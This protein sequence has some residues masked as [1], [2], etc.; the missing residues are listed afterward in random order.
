VLAPPPDPLLTVLTWNLDAGRGDLRAALADIAPRGDYLLLLQEAREEAV[1]AFAR[2]H[3][4]H[5]AFA[6]VRA[7]GAGNAVLSTLPLTEVR[8]ID[9]PRQR[10]PR[11]AVAAAIAVRGQ[12]LFVVSVHFEN[13]VSWW[14]GGLI[15]D[16]ARRRQAEALL[17]A[18]PA[19]APGIV[20]G[21][22]N[23]WLGP[24]EPAWRLLA[25]RFPDTPDL[26]APTFGDRLFLDH[27]FFDVPAGWTT[28]TRVAAERYRSNHHPVVGWIVSGG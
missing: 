8:T 21:D 10:Q 5:H 13:R 18:L 1:I 14:R 4:L 24:S 27:L 19:G 23:T 20:G 15:S 22:L 3:R 2:E 25:A 9:L 6:R 12:P 7:E 17:R 16:T 28:R 11:N 26:E